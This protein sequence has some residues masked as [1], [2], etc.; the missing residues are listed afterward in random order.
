MELASDV[1]NYDSEEDKKRK[2]I[3]EF[4]NR[5]KMNEAEKKEGG[6]PK[7]SEDYERIGKL[8]KPSDFEENIFEA[9]AK[10]KLTSIIYLL[11]NGSNVNSKDTS[12][13]G[14][15]LHYAAKKGHLSVVEYLINQKA[16]I[17]AKDNN[18]RTPMG[19]ASQWSKYNVVEFLKNKGGT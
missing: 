3:V 8:I 5:K 2:S 16:D 13:N 6:F 4:L 15:A 11:A 17:N 14:T 18:G 9:A 12:N 1:E 7:I 19:L 10:G